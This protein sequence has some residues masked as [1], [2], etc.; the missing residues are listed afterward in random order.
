M[1]L[2][3]HG[4]PGRMIEDTASYVNIE[5]V[6]THFNITWVESNQNPQ[7]ARLRSLVFAHNGYFFAFLLAGLAYIGTL[8]IVHVLMPNMT[9]LKDQLWQI[10]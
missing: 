3:T 2:D 7:N 4:I 1:K 8:E 10:E 9:P 5:T 6:R